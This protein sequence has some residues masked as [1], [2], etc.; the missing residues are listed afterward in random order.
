[1]RWVLARAVLLGS[2]TA[3]TGGDLKEGMPV[4]TDQK[5]AVS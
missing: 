2:L 1:M 4:I 5:A 3:C